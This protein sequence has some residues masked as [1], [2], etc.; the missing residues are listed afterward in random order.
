V[1]EEERRNIAFWKWRKSLKFCIGKGVPFFKIWGKYKTEL[2]SGILTNRRNFD[3]E[4]LEVPL[5]L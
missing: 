3:S 2:E 4:K 1:R 5:L